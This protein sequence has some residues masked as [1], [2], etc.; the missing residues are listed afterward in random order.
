M[1][2]EQYQELVKTIK[3]DEQ[4]RA[5]FWGEAGASVGAEREG[6]REVHNYS[7]EDW[8]SLCYGD[9]LKCQR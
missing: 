3:R 8:I 1:R 4:L 7:K 2:E 5:G 9:G 6:A